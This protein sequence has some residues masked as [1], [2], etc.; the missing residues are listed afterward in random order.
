[1]S[2]PVPTHRSGLV[3]DGRTRGKTVCRCRALRRD[4]TR[5]L[6]IRVWVWTDALVS[7]VVCGID[8]VTEEHRRPCARD[9]VEITR[10]L[11]ELPGAPRTGGR[12]PDAAVQAHGLRR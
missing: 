9:H 5:N 6:P 8:K 2:P 1:M 10:W 3:A 12:G 4:L 7:L 11:C